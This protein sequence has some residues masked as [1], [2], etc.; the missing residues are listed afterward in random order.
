NDADDAAVAVPAVA[1]RESQSPPV[2]VLADAVKDSVPPPA[3]AI[4]NCWLCGVPPVREASTTLDVPTLNCG[5]VPGSSD[6]ETATLAGAR[7][8]RTESAKKI[9]PEESMAIPLGES[10]EA[11]VARPPSPDDPFVPLPATVLIVPFESILRMRWLL[12]SL[13]KRLPAESTTIA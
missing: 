2:V 13:M 5:G 10:S 1:E 12:K 8:L 6:R 9:L 3:F 11:R 4:C 7:I